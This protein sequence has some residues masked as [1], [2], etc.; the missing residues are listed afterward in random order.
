M[1]TNVAGSSASYPTNVRVV[2]DGDS[3]DAATTVLA[4]TDLADRTAYLRLNCQ[5]LVRMTR[6]TPFAWTGTVGAVTARGANPTEAPVFG[7]YYTATEIVYASGI[8][9]IAVNTGSAAAHIYLMRLGSDILIHGRTLST[10]KVRYRG[11]SGHA[12][13]PALMP[14]IHISRNDLGQFPGQSNALDLLSTGSGWAVDTSADTTAYQVT[15]AHDITYTPNQNNVI[16]H[17]QYIYTLAFQNE[18]HTNAIV[19]GQ[20]HTVLATHT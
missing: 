2:A 6:F 9:F 1:T 5:P 14:A 11:M 12:G 3:V 10:L 18:A 13:L 17:T 20:L 15:N 16:D 19:G 7:P 4:P 8:K